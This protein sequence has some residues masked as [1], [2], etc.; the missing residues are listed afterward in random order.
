M[1]DTFYNKSNHRSTR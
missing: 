1:V